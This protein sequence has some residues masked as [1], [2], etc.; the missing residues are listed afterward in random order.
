[1]HVLAGG[2]LAVGLD[3]SSDGGKWAGAGTV[4]AGIRNLCV[5]TNTA[6]RPACGSDLQASSRPSRRAAGT[7]TEIGLFGSRWVHQ[8]RASPRKLTFR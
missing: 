2:P 7:C 1:M 8:R 6:V 3:A 4:N 5:I